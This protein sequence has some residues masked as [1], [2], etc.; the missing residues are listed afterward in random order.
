MAPTLKQLRYLAELEKL[1]N[2]SR[3]AEVC[4]VTQSTLSGGIR[5]LEEML[6]VGLFERTRR[7]VIPTPVGSQLADRARRILAETDGFVEVAKSHVAPYKGSLRLGVIP[8]IGP[9][10]LPRI[11]P[12]IRTTFPELKLILREDQTA[13]LLAQLSAGTLDAVILAFPCDAP[14]VDRFIFLDDP[15]WFAAPAGHP[16]SDLKQVSL[17]DAP[18][19]ELLL[20][21][22]GHCLRDHALSACKL[23]AAP[24]G[25][26]IIGTS[27]YTLL[28]MVSG[29]LGVTL[30]PQMALGTDILRGMDLVYRPMSAD[31]PSRQIGFAWRRTSGN[32]KVLKDLGAMLSDTLKSAAP[33]P[34]KP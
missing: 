14:E 21:E 29:G 18:L 33:P 12:A 30:V 15:F 13:R 10:L 26:D 34:R 20:L 28:Q 25:E 8:T 9:F 16:I 3:A 7:K 19:D 11:V 22:D 24:K 32:K 27:L 6:G 17:G 2:F 23:E 1:R 31:A 5:D 4:C